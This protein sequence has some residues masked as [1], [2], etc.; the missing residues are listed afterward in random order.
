MSEFQ[1]IA[2]HDD[3]STVP[4]PVTNSDKQLASPTQSD[5]FIETLNQWPHRYSDKTKY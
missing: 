5:I 2:G 3:F 4:F 1:L